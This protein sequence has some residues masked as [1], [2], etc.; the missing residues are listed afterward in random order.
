MIQNLP[1]NLQ[2]IAVIPTEGNET[3]VLLQL[4]TQTFDPTTNI[5]RITNAK[6][7]TYEWLEKLKQLIKMGPVVVYSQYESFSGILGLVKCI[8][9]EIGFNSLQC[10]S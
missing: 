1:H 4:I 2:L 3:L 8:R 5:L 6:N 9:R 7:E 10:L